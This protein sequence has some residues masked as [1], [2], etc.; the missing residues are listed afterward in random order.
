MAHRPCCNEPDT[1]VNFPHRPTSWGTRNR[2]DG[3]SPGPHG[4]GVRGPHGL[5]RRR[6]RVHDVRRVGRRG[7]RHGAPPAR[8]RARAQRP[9][10]HPPPARAGPAL[11]RVVLGGAP[12]RRRGRADE[13]PPG[14]G[15]GGP[16]ARA[17]GRHRRGGR[18]RPAAQR[19]GSRGG[20]PRRPGRRRC[21]G[22][23]GA[24]GSDGPVPVLGWAEATA[25]DRSPFQAPRR[26]RGPGRHPLHL[27]DDRAPQGRGRPPLQRVDD[28]RGRAELDRRR[29]AARQPT[30]SPSPAS[31]SCTRP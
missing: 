29:L 8:V 7:Q 18:R 17:L 14:P 27:G 4:R 10:R 13:P 26:V 12:G 31:P 2:V 19:P 28:R 15:R 21:R 1:G 5:R 20:P 25:G 23:D 30:R 11:A 6:R 9:G 24:A 22:R 16:H 3:R